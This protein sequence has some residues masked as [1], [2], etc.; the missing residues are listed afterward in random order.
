MLQFGIATSRSREERIRQVS[1]R[2]AAAIAYVSFVSACALPTLP[3]VTE[4][5]H[6]LCEQHQRVPTPDGYSLTADCYPGEEP[7]IVFIHGWSQARVVWTEQLTSLAG[8]KLLI[9]YD[10]RG[11]GDSARPRDSAAFLGEWTPATDV[12]AVLDYFGVQHAV[13][14]GWSFG[15]IVA[16]NAAV[17]LGR[18][19]VSGLVLVSGTTESGT[20]RNVDS[21]G[22][23]LD[24]VGPMTAPASGEEERQAVHHFLS[25][26]FVLGSWPRSLYEQIFDANMRLTSTERATVALRPTQRFATG[27][28]GWGMPVLLIHGAED[29]VFAVE[30][31]REAHAEL[32]SSELLIY[33][34]TGHWPFLE[35]PDRF[36][37]DL[38]RFVDGLNRD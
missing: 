35:Q 33:D 32:D 13:L 27:L 8:S 7:A 24:E 28:N 25:E 34:D 31:S 26:S 37:R 30:S 23:L 17:H 19:R 36:N 1:V 38:R 5:P 9:S 22:P 20:Q 14:V 18:D 12:E 16:A 29:P 2:A 3:R 21:F 15:S 11:H 4:M 6:S 10:L